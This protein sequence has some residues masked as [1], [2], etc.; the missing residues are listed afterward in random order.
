MQVGQVLELGG[1]RVDGRSRWCFCDWRSR[2][3][4]LLVGGS[5]LLS[6]LIASVVRDGRHTYDPNT[7]TS[8]HRVVPFVLTG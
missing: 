7:S 6:A 8:H 5:L 1:C 4:S 2:R 3:G